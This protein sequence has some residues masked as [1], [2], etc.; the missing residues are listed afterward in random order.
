[1]ARTK[2]NTQNNT[3]HVEHHDLTFI[4]KTISCVKNI[5]YVEVVIVHFINIWIYLPLSVIYK[6]QYT[7]DALMS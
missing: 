2:T 6:L 7:C 5:K 4:K 1:M 3:K